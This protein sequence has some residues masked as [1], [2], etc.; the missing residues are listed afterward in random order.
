MLSE[1][2]A[3]L[4]LREGGSEALSDPRLVDD[5]DTQARLVVGRAG[6]IWRRE[7]DSNPRWGISPHTISN[8]AP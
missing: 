8:R 6:L 3:F 7:R 5:V 4:R 1:P 2:G